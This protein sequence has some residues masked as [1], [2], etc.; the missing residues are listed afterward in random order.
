MRKPPLLLIPQGLSKTVSDE[1]RLMS[2]VS[3]WPR[4][5]WF[6]LFRHVSERLFRVDSPVY[7]LEDGKL[8]TTSVGLLLLP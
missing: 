4:A 5:P 7:I 2:A 8:R 1:V 3:E 6:T